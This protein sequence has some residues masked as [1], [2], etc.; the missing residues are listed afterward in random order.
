[1]NLERAMH[2]KEIIAST[3]NLEYL[4]TASKCPSKYYSECSE[5]LVI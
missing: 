2:V 1:M 3:Y 5:R 4:L